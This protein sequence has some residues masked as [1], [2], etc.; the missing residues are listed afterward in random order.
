[1]ILYVQYTKKFHSIWMQ[2]REYKEE[3][4]TLSLE[5]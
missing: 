4:I 5:V 2:E 3:Y 1:M